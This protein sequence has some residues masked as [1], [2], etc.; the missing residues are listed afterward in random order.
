MASPVI[1][2]SLQMITFSFNYCISTLNC[3]YSLLSVYLFCGFGPNDLNR[4]I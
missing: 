1:P 2:I 4:T 3:I